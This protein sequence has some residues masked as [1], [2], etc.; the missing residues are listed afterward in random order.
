M[1]N[2]EIWRRHTVYRGTQHGHLEWLIV[3]LQRKLLPHNLCFSLAYMIG[4]SH[5]RFSYRTRVRLWFRQKVWGL[6]RL[7]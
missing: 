6:N 2:V 5:V 4:R 3:F 1:I 7:L